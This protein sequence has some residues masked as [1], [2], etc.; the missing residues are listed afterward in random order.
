MVQRVQ[1]ATAR[2][3]LQVENDSDFVAGGTTS[4]KHTK[5]ACDLSAGLIVAMRMCRG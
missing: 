3:C 5:V 4:W 2:G 1:A